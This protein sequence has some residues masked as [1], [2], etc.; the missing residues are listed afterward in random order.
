MDGTPLSLNDKEND[1]VVTDE[2]EPPVPRVR[3]L[4][5]STVYHRSARPVVRVVSTSTAVAENLRAHLL[6]GTDRD[7]LDK[8]SSPSKSKR[9]KA[10][11]TK[12]RATTSKSES[13]N[14]G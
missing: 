3:R 9:R 1:L 11:S 5:N 12:V 13:A 14:T 6:E 7:L 10:D 8:S 4:S 2:P